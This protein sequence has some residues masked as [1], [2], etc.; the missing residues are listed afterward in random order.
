MEGRGQPCRP[1]M[2]PHTEPG[3]TAD[4]SSAPAPE[5]RSAAATRADSDPDSP[6]IWGDA[7]RISLLAD[8]ALGDPA[9][10]PPDPPPL[11]WVPVPPP[12]GALLRRHALVCAAFALASIPLGERTLIGVIAGC[13]IALVNL[14]GLERSVH[15]ML[16]GPQAPHPFVLRIFLHLR[17]GLLLALVAVVLLRGGVAPL[18]FTVGLSSI[19]PAVLWHG[20]K[21][22]YS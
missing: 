3:E 10:E 13:A 22:R 17:I 19:V 8:A 12:S 18:A 1:E 7:E 14:R 5:P 11:P 20:W 9:E 16:G 21:S 15:R 6:G 4:S 2:D